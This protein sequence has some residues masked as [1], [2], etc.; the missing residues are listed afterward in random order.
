MGSKRVSHGAVMLNGCI[1]V[2]GGWNGQGV[3]KSVEV[4]RPERGEWEVVSRYDNI[5]MKS[6]VAAMDSKIY[7]VGGCLQTLDACYRADVFDTV[8]LEWSSLPDTNH[9]RATP[10]LVLYVFGGELNSQDVVKYYDPFTNKWTVMAD[11]RIKHF[12]NGAYVGCL[13]E[14]PWDWDIQQA[15]EGSGGAANMQRLLSVVGLDVVQT[16]RS[17][18]MYA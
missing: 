6:D 7:V 14:K 18:G 1:Y 5:R 9:S 13:V 16:A 8:T 2:V 15:R 17:L 3:V 12:V 10:V 4:L 11:S